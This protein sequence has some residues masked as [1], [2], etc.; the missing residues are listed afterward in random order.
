MEEDEDLEL[1][2]EELTEHNNFLINALIDLLIE[3]KIIS[4]DEFNKKVSEMQDSCED[5]PEEEE[6]K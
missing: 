4:E 6:D 2:S 1:G 3:K 5:E